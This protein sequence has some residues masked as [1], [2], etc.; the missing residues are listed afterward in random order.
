MDVHNSYKSRLFSDKLDIAIAAERIVQLKES[1]IEC[2]ISKHTIDIR[3]EPAKK[4]GSKPDYGNF[5]FELRKKDLIHFPII[6]NFEDNFK[7]TGLTIL[8]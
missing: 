7:F 6:L 2:S 4:R 3:I 5:A 1:G 8:R